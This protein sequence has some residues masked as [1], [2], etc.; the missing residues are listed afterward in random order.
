M[1]RVVHALGTI[2]KAQINGVKLW[3]TPKIGKNIWWSE[4]FRKRTETE[5]L[6]LAWR[7]WSYSYV[8]I[9]ERV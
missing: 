1:Q 3:A 2:K 5:L 9:V 7:N 8:Y 4:S 6:P